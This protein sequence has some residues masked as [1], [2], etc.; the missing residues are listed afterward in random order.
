LITFGSF[1]VYTRVEKK[2]LLPSVAFTSLSLFMILRVP[3]D[4]ISD[5]LASIMASK[6]S[7]DRVE[8]YLKEPE[9]E[10]YNQL[11]LKFTDDGEP[12]IGFEKAT[13]SWG[14][15]GD[16]E[17]DSFRLIDLSVDFQPGRF[18]LIVGPTGAGKTS[19][20]MA[21]LGE[22]SLLEGN[23][24]LPGS[25]SR[26]DLKPNPR[27][28]LIES[29]AYCA[30]QAWLVN[31]SIKENILF[32]SEFNEKRYNDVLEA[33]A[34]Q[35][36]LEI[37]DGK[38]ETL[39]GE[40]GVTL[41]GGQKQRISLARALYSNSR[42]LLLDDV[43]SAVDSHT[44]KWIFE[45]A[46]L[47]PLMNN[48]S[49]ILITHN[50]SLALPHAD[51]A[52]VLDNGR[53]VARGT[54]QEVLKSGKLQDDVA[55]SL[56][57]S[58][59]HSRAGSTVP[60]HG[61]LT[62]LAANGNATEEADGQTKPANKA[63][64][65]VQVET[66]SVGSVSMSVYLIYF[67]AMGSWIFWLFA[68]STFV[69]GQLISVATNVW[70]REWANAYA[71]K[72][73][74]TY[75]RSLPGGV[76]DGLKLQLPASGMSKIFEAVQFQS[77]IFANSSVFIDRAPLGFPG[78]SSFGAP[79]PSFHFG[80]SPFALSDATLGA[81][82]TEEKVD[83]MYYLGV[84]ALLGVIVMVNTFLRDILIFYGSITA[85]KRIHTRLLESVMH[86]KFRFFDSTPLGQIMNR[87]SKDLESVDQQI[88][89]SA[90]GFFY[91]VLSVLAVVILIS[92]ITPGFIVA[93][94]FIS[95]MYFLIGTL[96]INSSRDL[97]RLES[98]NRS[99]LY[100]QF[101]ETL[102]GMTTIRAYCD[103]RRFVRENLNRINVQNRPFIFL[104]AANR[105][106]AF[107]VDVVGSLVS[108]FSGLFVVVNAG[109][110]DPG[111]AGLSLSYALT[112]TGNILWLVRLYA[113]NEQNMNAMERIKEYMEVEVEAP[114]IVEENRP[115]KSWPSKGAISFINYS[116]RYRTDFDLVL[117][118]L[119]F[120]VLAGEKVGVVGRTGAGKSSMALALFRA[121]EADEGQILV[122]DVDIAA[123]GLQDLREKIVMVPQDPTLFSGTIRSNL[124]PFDLFTNEE[125]FTALR[126]V[127]LIDSPGPSSSATPDAPGTPAIGLG[128][129]TRSD[130][131]TL[132]QSTASAL[133]EATAVGDT[134]HADNKN[135]FQ[136]LSSRVAES[137]S[138]LSQ[139]QRQLLC[140]A[141]ALLKEPAV[142]VMDEATA[143]IDHATDG[144]IQETI[145]LLRNTTVT[146]AHR[147]K[148][149]VDYDK[150][151][152]LDRGRVV[153][154]GEPWDLMEREGGM[155]AGMCQ[156]SGDAGALRDI[157]KRAKEEKA[158]AS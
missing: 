115:P 18:N 37:F 88:T 27:T 22:M 143:S 52:V 129:S 77:P 40:K 24:Y 136:N 31:A 35:R 99:P 9:T 100:Q 61:D 92:V 109:K 121:L 95:I 67:A 58:K 50:V 103:E 32:A 149:I 13:F 104:W 28:G 57:I 21:L 148:T 72:A 7:V 71:R 137:G 59:N 82:S 128:R 87:F 2:D 73:S 117:T 96:Y 142:L 45:K 153:E 60:S 156:E 20:L 127:Q 140:L 102:V 23:V 134:L 141:R 70:L 69:G 107:R 111:A 94:L 30:Q 36:D 83:D 38:D 25:K 26:E 90:I 147:L 12:V 113:N 123:I 65:H 110:I 119:N 145:R 64:V 85:S 10:K 15:K 130:G 139:G 131:S 124:D 55:S 84:Y 155:F 51:F 56:V 8:E 158:Q 89:G 122:D 68:L 46:I 76:G 19:M 44:A 126:K 151:L 34:L 152:V 86:A 43:L 79:A 114:Q 16:A 125:L 29:T 116:T 66:K 97:K 80:T 6:A 49:V 93:G 5:M 105:W 135:V 146:I 41:S 63:E 53:V 120:K 42:H 74:S 33:C 48:R 132:A 138:N 75:Q 157:A 81:L 133:S 118:K 150:V 4:Q 108:F 144:K 3:L 106:L 54:P 78:A 39:V 154:F 112:Y 101:G 14:L 91:C 98:V 62:A 17:T 47:G 11:N 1:Y